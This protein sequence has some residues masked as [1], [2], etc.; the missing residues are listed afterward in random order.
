[1]NENRN[2]FWTTLPGILTG[3]AALVTAVGVIYFG[4]TRSPQ[5]TPADSRTS[6]ALQSS[7][8]QPQPEPHAQAKPQPIN[9][10]QPPEPTA[11]PKFTGP[12]GSLEPGISYS[13]GDIYDRPS[14]SPE[15]CSKLCFNDDRCRAVTFIISQQRCWIKNQVN[16]PQQSSDMVSA[17]KEG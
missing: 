17:R 3:L 16:A 13:S 11:V 5:P 10:Y 7:Q 15:E 14:R 12:M 2:S 9:D 6:A 1:M 4:S 8:S